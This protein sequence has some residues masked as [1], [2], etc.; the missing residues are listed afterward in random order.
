MAHGE[1]MRLQALQALA[2]AHGISHSPLQ[3]GLVSVWLSGARF[4][5]EHAPSAAAGTE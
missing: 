3:T 4:A 2:D 5:E 1:K